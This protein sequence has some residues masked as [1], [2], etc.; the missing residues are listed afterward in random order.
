M[1]RCR[2]SRGRYLTSAL[3]LLIVLGAAAPMVRADSVAADARRAIDL[4][5]MVPHPLDLPGGYRQG[6]GYLSTEIEDA[7]DHPFFVPANWGSRLGDRAADLLRQTGWQRTYSNTL[8]LPD[9]DDPDEYGLSMRFGVSEFAGDDDAE[10]ARNGL[11]GLLR[12]VGADVKPVALKPGFFATLAVFGAPEADSSPMLIFRVDAFVATIDFFD[13]PAIAY[14]AT[15]VVTAGTRFLAQIETVIASTDSTLGGHAVRLRDD[16]GLR[17]TNQWYLRR[18]GRDVP[19]FYDNRDVEIRRLAFGDATDVYDIQP[20]FF[21]GGSVLGMHI[22]LLRFPSEEAALAWTPLWTIYLVGWGWEETDLA[23]DGIRA[24]RQIVF[25]PAPDSEER[26][27]GNV[28]ILVDGREAV[29]VNVVGID[30][31]NTVAGV[32]QAQM[33]CL[34]GTG[35]CEPVSFPRTEPDATPRASPVASASM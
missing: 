8:G 7:Y 33:D 3:A 34:R 18:D 25:L 13:A 2:L 10:T 20:L 21:G 14:R 24:D 5:A 17:L 23:V 28:V 35:A 32:A 4:A 12:E 9:P 31:V 27:W 19:P 1:V 29:V 6:S 16:D 30:A 22:D 11:A 15:D 26:W